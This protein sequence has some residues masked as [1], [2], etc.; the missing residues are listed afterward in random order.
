MIS[1][2]RGGI[3]N[4][5]NITNFGKRCIST[6]CSTEGFWAW[7]HSTKLYKILESKTIASG[8]KIDSYTYLQNLLSQFS[9]MLGQFHDIRP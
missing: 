4:A 5:Q 3:E 8:Q 7:A 9:K 6:Q 1:S 2:L